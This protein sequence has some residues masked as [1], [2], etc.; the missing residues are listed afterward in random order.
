MLQSLHKTKN[1]FNQP[2]LSQKYARVNSQNTS[3]ENKEVGHFTRKKTPQETQNKLKRL[4][5]LF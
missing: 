4:H 1:L 5:Q 3:N 2:N